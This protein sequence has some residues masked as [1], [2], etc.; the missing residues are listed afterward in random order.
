MPPPPKKPV[1]S[2]ELPVLTEHPDGESRIP[3]LTEELRQNLS[4]AIA[5][6]SGPLSDAQCRELAAEL[7]PQLEAMLRAKFVSH[8]EA[9]WE[10]SWR[11]VEKALPGLIRDQLAASPRRSPK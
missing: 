11:D 10:K 7:A 5:P 9:W 6:K 4:A 2:G 8:F 1:K 3:V